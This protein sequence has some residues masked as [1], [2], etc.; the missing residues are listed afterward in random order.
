MQD[1]G[2]EIKGAWSVLICVMAILS[3]AAWTRLMAFLDLDWRVLTE[4]AGG[5]WRMLV[6]EAV[7]MGAAVEPE[8]LANTFEIT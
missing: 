2:L 1:N 5:R 4:E 6:A 3:L 7:E 8:V